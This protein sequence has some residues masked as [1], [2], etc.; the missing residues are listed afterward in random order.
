M[1]PKIL[2]HHIGVAL[3]LLVTGCRAMLGIED[4]YLEDDAAAADVALPDSTA[5]ADGGDG[6]ITASD[7]GRPSLEQCVTWC[8]TDGGFFAGSVAF[9]AELRSCMCQGSKLVACAT[10][11]GGLCPNGS[12][13]TTACETCIMQETL[14]AGGLC[15]PTAASCSTPCRSFRQCV[16]SCRQ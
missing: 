1:S 12:N 16:V 2:A 3:L 8:R 13:S 6:S 10:E 11:C 15:G 9:V 5:V 14:D 7:G 4:V